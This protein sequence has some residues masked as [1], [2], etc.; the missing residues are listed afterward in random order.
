MFTPEIVITKQMKTE[1]PCISSM[2]KLTE[3]FQTQTKMSK[4]MIAQNKGFT[5]SE[6]EPV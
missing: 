1:E 3:L 6:I 5:A 2:K 4:L